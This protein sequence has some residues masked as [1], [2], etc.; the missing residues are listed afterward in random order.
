M[1]AFTAGSLF[2]E[3]RHLDSKGRLPGI[4]LHAVPAD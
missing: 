4:A 3:D 2:V 1:H